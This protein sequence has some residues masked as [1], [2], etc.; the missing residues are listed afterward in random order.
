MLSPVPGLLETDELTG[1]LTNMLDL[2]RNKRCGKEDG[3]ISL[4]LAPILVIVLF[5]VG[6]L[7]QYMSFST[8]SEIK[9]LKGRGSVR[10]YDFPRDEVFQT[11][12]YLIDEMGFTVIES[13]KE[14]YIIATEGSDFLNEGRIIALFFTSESPNRTQVE[15][16]S[17]FMALPR[18]KELLLPRN[19][20]SNILDDLNKRLEKSDGKR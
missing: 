3:I 15:V 18:L 6:L 9:G 5:L 2:K 16:V 12:I 13:D 4:I 1:I 7:F 17:R 8:P 10:T 19:G 11:S 20:I 14:D